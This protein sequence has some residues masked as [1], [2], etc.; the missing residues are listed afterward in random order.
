[1]ILSY[2]PI[3]EGDENRSCAGREPSG[4]DL[5]AVRRADA[6][7]LN[8][9]CYRSLYEMVRQNCRHVFPNYDVKFA[10]PG[11]S[12]Q[13][14][15]FRSEGVPHPATQLYR[16]V[17]SF[18]A[19]RDGSPCRYPFPF[20]MVF[21]F[22]WGGE[23]ETVHLL[24]DEKHLIHLLDRAGVFESSGQSGFLLQERIDTPRTLRVVVVG[25]TCVS[26][27]RVGRE[28]SGFHGNLAKGGG[29]DRTSDPDLQKAA[30]N[31]A[32]DFCRNT[33]INLAGLD[34]LF[35]SDPDP[36][37]PLFLEINYYFGRRGLGGSEPYYR[38]L[39]REIRRWIEDIG[40]PKAKTIEPA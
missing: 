19:A 2:H 25:Q 12:G 37:V 33:G 26:Y 1:M 4:E 9:G 28:R 17:E 34:F 32:Q 15:L 36:P 29:I 40:E 11:K 5:E 24:Q 31:A 10:Y 39:T 7:V 8:Q 14:R 20:P 3:F 35:A 22:D 27:W 30:I 13:I 38:L 6:V 21:K 16:N 23:G 18:G